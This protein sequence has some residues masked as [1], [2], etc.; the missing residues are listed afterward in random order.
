MNLPTQVLNFEHLFS[1]PGCPFRNI[2]SFITWLLSIF[3]RCA[4]KSISTAKT[5]VSCR[6]LNIRTELNI[7]SLVSIFTKRDR[8]KTER[9]RERKNLKRKQNDSF[10]VLDVKEWNNS[11]ASIFLINFFWM[12]SFTNFFRFKLF[13]CSALNFQK[14]FLKLFQSHILFYFTDFF[15]YMSV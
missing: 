2:D 6:K 13:I 12:W 1:L 5:Y 7:C 3:I 4:S 11:S 9:Q 15:L 10:F 14:S 8:E